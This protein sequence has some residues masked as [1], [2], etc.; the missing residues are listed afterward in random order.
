MPAAPCGSGK[1]AVSFSKESS[2]RGNLFA[3]LKESWRI[4]SGSETQEDEE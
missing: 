2:S 3:F 1:E 4:T